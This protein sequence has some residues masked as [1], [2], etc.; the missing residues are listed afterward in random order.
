MLRLLLPQRVQSSDL[1][2]YDR[3][4]VATYFGLEGDVLQHSRQSAP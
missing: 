2:D 1:R 3:W 4:V